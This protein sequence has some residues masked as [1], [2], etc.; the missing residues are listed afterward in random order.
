MC[1]VVGLGRGVAHFGYGLDG[2]IDIF[3]F[4]FSQ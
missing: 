1:G 4:L 3:L 2:V